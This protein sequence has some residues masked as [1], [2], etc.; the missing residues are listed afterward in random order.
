VEIRQVSSEPINKS[1]SIIIDIPQCLIWDRTRGGG[2]FRRIMTVRSF[3]LPFWAPLTLPKYSYLC[4]VPLLVFY[5]VTLAAIKYNQVRN[6]PQAVTMRDA[7]KSALGIC[8]NSINEGR[9]CTCSAMESKY[10]EMDDRTVRRI[11]SFLGTRDRIALGRQVILWLLPGKKT[12]SSNNRAQLLAFSSHFEARGIVAPQRLFLYLGC[13][14]F[15]RSGGSTHCRYHYPS[16]CPQGGLPFHFHWDVQTA[17]ERFPVRGLD[18]LYGFHWK[19]NHHYF[20]IIRCV[21]DP[22]VF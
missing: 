21:G 13:R 7:N 17:Y 4:S 6:P 11:Q 22:P 10:T 12:C 20:L 15:A 19:F 9:P 5:S 14:V 18:I 16:R 1:T 2:G 8:F 3:F